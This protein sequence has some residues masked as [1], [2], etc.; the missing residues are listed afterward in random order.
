MRGMLIGPA[1]ILQRSSVHND[2]P[3]ATVRKRIASTLNDEVLDL[4]K[5]DIK[6]TQIDEPVIRESPPLKYVDWDAYLNW[7]DEALRL[8]SAGCEGNMQIHIHMC[9]SE[10]N[11]ILPAVAA[12]GADA[13]TI[14]IS[15][16]DMELLVAFGDFEHSNNIGPGVYDIHSPRVPTEAKIEHPLR[17]ALDMI[18]VARL[19]VNPDRGLKAHG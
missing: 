5:V 10:L 6:V 17:K 11:D 3:C 13:V 19:W 14:E 9:Y 2:I 1:T 12:L 16:S 4:E 15:R 8:L 7:A 18:P